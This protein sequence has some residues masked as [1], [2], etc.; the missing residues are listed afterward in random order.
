MIP[1]ANTIGFAGQELARKL[2]KVL[3]VLIET[4]LG[5]LV[6]IVLFIVLIVKGDE[7]IPVVRAA[8][9]GSILANLL[10]CMGLCFVAGGL[11]HTEQIYHE[12]ISET[13]NGLLLVAGSKSFRLRQSS[14]MPFLHYRARTEDRWRPPGHVSQALRSI[15]GI[16]RNEMFRVLVHSCTVG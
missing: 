7:K 14:I 15:A 4:T 1:A 11:R 3:G 10:L 8:I 2:P 5:S 6:E 13:G 9:L 16:I 12:T